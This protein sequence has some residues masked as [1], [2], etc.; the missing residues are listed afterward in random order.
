[1]LSEIQRQN[2]ALC[3]SEERFR[4]LF[5]NATIGL[6]RSLPDGEFVMANPALIRLL[7]CSSL[8]ELNEMRASRDFTSRAE[9]TLFVDA[10]MQQGGLSG[11]ESKWTTRDASI[12]FVRESAHVIRGPAGEVQY[13]EGTVEDITASKRAEAELES[14]HQQLADASRQAG[15]AE[16]ATGVLHNIGNVLNT[17]NVSTTLVADKLRTSRLASLTKVVRMLDQHGT[18]LGS[19]LTETEKGRQVPAFLGSLAKVLTQEQ[20]RLLKE[21]ESLRKNVE[22]MKGIVAMQQN[23]ARVSGANEVA[24]LKD[25]AEDALK[26]HAGG[27]SRLGIRVVREFEVVPRMLVCRHKVLLILVNLIR[28]AQFALGASGN[29]DRV[30][31]IRVGKE[32]E[33]AKIQ[34]IDN[35]IGIPPEN[36]TRIFEHGFTTRKGGHG[37]GL[38]SGALAAKEMGGSLTAESGG[39]GTGAVFTLTIPIRVPGQS[40]TL[41]SRMNGFTPSGGGVAVHDIS[42]G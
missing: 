24:T 2:E 31:T 40:P 19:F 42:V 36:L 18:D 41:I 15:M 17:V 14:L 26:F 5:E 7:G 8:A 6:Y 13:F 23:Y 27:M 3:Q 12:V 1:M 20:A 30:L 21:L 9:R 4:T 35:G 11:I 22:H 34:V 38:H 32:G 37:F 10:L 28:N 39:V 33:V 16:M 25:L 29:T